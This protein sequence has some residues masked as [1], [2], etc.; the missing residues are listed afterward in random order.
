MICRIRSSGQTVR[1][2]TLCDLRRAH[3]WCTIVFVTGAGGN[4]SMAPGTYARH[5]MLTTS[6]RR[7]MG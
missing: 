1:G 7:V 6:A 3:R 5:A 4:S 2:P